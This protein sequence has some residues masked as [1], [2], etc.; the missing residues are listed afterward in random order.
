MKIRCIA[1]FATGVALWG[2]AVQK[3]MTPIGGSRSDGV[4]R[5]AFTYGMFENP[6]VDYGQAQTAARQRCAAWGYSDA[7]AFG[8]QSTQCTNGTYQGCNQWQVTVEYQCT[9]Q[10]E[11]TGS[12]TAN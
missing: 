7:E 4:V 1:A 5:L 10:P 8:G 6:K 2:C 12:K 3:V 11:A 9:G